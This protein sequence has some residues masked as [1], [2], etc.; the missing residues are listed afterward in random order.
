LDGVQN[1]IL[2]VAQIA[3]EKS[4]DSKKAEAMSKVALRQSSDLFGNLR[5]GNGK[6][7]I[8]PSMDA[9]KVASGST[10]PSLPTVAV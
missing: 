10:L 7:N 4:G 3:N 8:G 9:I 6:M 1:G 5:G 2:Q